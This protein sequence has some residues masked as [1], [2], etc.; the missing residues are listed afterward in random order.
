M[1]TPWV[2]L[3]T[4]RIEQWN[5][6]CAHLCLP[7]MRSPISRRL[8][9]ITSL[10]QRLV[11]SVDAPLRSHRIARNLLP[12][13]SDPRRVHITKNHRMDANISEWLSPCSS[14][15][16]SCIMSRPQA[17]R[18]EQLLCTASGSR[19]LIIL[20]SCGRPLQLRKC[21]RL[22]ALCEGAEPST[23]GYLLQEL[24]VPGGDIED[25]DLDVLI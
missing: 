6:N 13:L 20:R 11:R 22:A 24:I 7:L 2:R 25:I 21:V 18:R 10:L 16:L 8:R 15:R 17:A 19:D 9:G 3:V 23:V 12:R 1:R 5:S 14:T 4:T